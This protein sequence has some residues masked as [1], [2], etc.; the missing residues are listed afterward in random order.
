MTAPRLRT[1]WRPLTREGIIHRDLKPGNIMITPAGVKVLDFGVAK[2]TAA[3]MTMT[4]PRR[5]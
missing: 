3:A 1:P 5:L 4:E 2:R